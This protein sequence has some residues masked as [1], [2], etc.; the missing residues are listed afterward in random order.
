MKRFGMI[1]VAI[2]MLIICSFARAGSP[3]FGLDDNPT[4]SIHP[5]LSGYPCIG[6][7]AEDPFALGTYGASGLAPSPSLRV[8]G[9]GSFPYFVDAD[10]L[11]AGQTVPL[12]HLTTPNG[13]WI[14]SFSDNTQVYTSSVQLDFSVDRISKGLPGTAVNNQFSLNQQPGDIFRTTRSFPSPGNFVGTLQ[15]GAGYSGALVSVS[16]SGSNTLVLDESALTLTASGTPGVLTG[17]SSSA[18][19]I[20]HGTHDNVDS[21]EW[22]AFNTIGEDKTDTWLYFSVYPTEAQVMNISAANIYDVAPGNGETS[23]S[24]PFAASPSLG[25]DTLGLNTDNIDALVLYDL[26]QL[27]GPKWNGPGAEA[28]IDYALFS[29]SHGSASL[30][31][32]GLSEADIFFTDFTGSFALYASAA[33]LGLA[34]GTG[35][36]PGDNVD[37]LE[38]V[39]EPATLFLFGFGGLVLLRKRKA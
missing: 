11:E 20:A 26:N 14:S 6:L 13:L 24:R 31:T 34:G 23:P 29:L 10:I 16:G 21:F 8:V 7:G 22:N 27:G 19:T 2:S 32:L 37:A 12:N 3:V 15:P 28:G 35:F 5:E 17:P 1:C 9:A 30:N 25:L 33:D 36:T 39:P 4:M 18:M 38:I